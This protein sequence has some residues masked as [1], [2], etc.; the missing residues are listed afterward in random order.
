M[1]QTSFH[2]N[3]PEGTADIVSI[4]TQPPGTW[5]EVTVGLDVIIPRGVDVGEHWLWC[6]S[7]VAESGDKCKPD[8]WVFFQPLYNPPQ[9]VDKVCHWQM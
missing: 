4:T 6:S 7:V 2:S 8:S 9:T 1:R 3:A 5:Q